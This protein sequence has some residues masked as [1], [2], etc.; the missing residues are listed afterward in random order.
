MGKPRLR[1][2]SLFIL[3]AMGLTT[4]AVR[5]VWVQGFES[6]RYVEIATQ[7]RERRFTLPPQ[8]GS[9]YD[10]DGAE[11][12]ISMD[13]QTVFANPHFVPDAAAAAHSLAPLL[14]AD[15]AEL[16]QKLERKS[17]FVYLAR[18]IDS[19]LAD[20]IRALGIPGVSLV[21]ESKRFYPAGSLGAHVLGFVGLDNNGLGGIEGHYEER[22]RGE[23]GEVLM[24]RDPAGRPI[25]AGTWRLRPPTAGDRLVLT[26]DREIQFAAEK[27]LERTVTEFTAVGGSIV[28]LRPSTGEVL[29]MANMPNFDPNDFGS[30]NDEARRNRAVTDMYEPGSTSKVVTAA[31]AIESEVVSPAEV[32]SVPDRLQIGSKVFTDYRPHPVLDL[33]FADV[34]AQSSNVGTLKVAQELGKERLHDYLGRFGYGRRTGIDFPGEA[35]GMLPDVN[36][37]WTTSMGTIP[38]GQG[39]AVTPLQM[40]SVLATVANGG[41]AVTPRL[42][43][44][45]LDSR[46]NRSPV[47]AL[48]KRRVIEER[49]SKK[50]TEI[51][52]GV[53]EK[54]SGTG[55]MA[56]VPGYQVAGKTG[57]ADRVDAQNGGYQGYVTSFVGFAPAGDPQLAIGVVIDNPSVHFGSVTA[58]PAFKEVMQFALRHLGIGPGPV[59]PTEGTPLPGPVRSGGESVSSEISALPA[60]D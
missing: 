50:L 32:L 23:P 42:V 19:Q 55:K 49:T 8:R 22:L 36:G 39:V 28:V 48:E 10:R 7:Q 30:S 24:E 33:T 51:L 41:V 18:K 5:L 29:A 4:I 12:A 46:G 21:A 26:I 27:A 2:A 1:L 54:K 57:S 11:L 35:P 37:W 13:A 20:Q 59:L 40:T 38:I 56:R 34:I 25:P 45:T 43:L 52:L 58:A 17:G 60:G 16:I 47:G 14:Q 9:I 44:A 15:P 53:T 31:A 3:L 6:T